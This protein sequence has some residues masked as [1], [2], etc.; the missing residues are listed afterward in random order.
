MDIQH[1]A[2][3]VLETKVLQSN[4]RDELSSG[5]EQILELMQKNG[6]TELEMENTV[7]K[8]TE[9]PDPVPFP[10][11]IAKTLEKFYPSIS[12][13]QFQE[14]LKSIKKELGKKAS[15]PFLT[16]R[17]KKAKKG[18]KKKGAHKEVDTSDIV[19]EPI[20]RMSFTDFKNDKSET[21]VTDPINRLFANAAPL[22]SNFNG[23]IPMVVDGILLLDKLNSR[24]NT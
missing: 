22:N 18:S 10:K 8:I 5:K 9:K 23:P 16:I 2:E 24:L 3:R 19:F 11:V 20:K 4:H 15:H 7:F 1:L 13:E 12:A 21:K 14:Q 6:K 17:T